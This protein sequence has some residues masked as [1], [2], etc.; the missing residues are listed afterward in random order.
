MLSGPFVFEPTTFTVSFWS[1]GTSCCLFA[2]LWWLEEP[3]QT[4]CRRGR[5]FLSIKFCTIRK[6]ICN[7]GESSLSLRLYASVSLS[8][9]LF[10]L[11]AAPQ[12]HNSRS[13]SP[14]AKTWLTQQ[15]KSW[16]LDVIWIRSCLR[17]HCFN[18]SNAMMNWSSTSEGF[19]QIYF[20][21]QLFVDTQLQLESWVSA[22]LNKPDEISKRVF[23][24]IYKWKFPDKWFSFY[25][26][27]P[28]NESNFAMFRGQPAVTYLVLNMKYHKIANTN[29][30]GRGG[31]GHHLL[32]DSRSWEN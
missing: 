3:P 30:C 27:W 21:H 32:R 29:E 26:I 4:T 12:N 20:P 11:R 6:P 2:D 7:S 19:D 8:T 18:T 23:S 10:S 16:G 22:S 14:K 24:P 15:Q 28:Q 17:Q 5:F 9:R 25:S 13:K 1:S 31:G